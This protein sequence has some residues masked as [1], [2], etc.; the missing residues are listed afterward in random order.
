[1]RD[2]MLR[3]RRLRMEQA[4]DALPELDD[5]AP[6]REAVARAAGSHPG[7]RPYAVSR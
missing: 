4:F 6:L 2:A 1:M 3:P 7:A 5:L